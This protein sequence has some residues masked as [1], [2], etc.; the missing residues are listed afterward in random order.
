MGTQSGYSP[1][2]A[3][4][5]GDALRVELD[6][7][8]P[9]FADPEYRA[10]RDEIAAISAGYRPGSAIARVDY[11]ETEHDVWRIVSRELAP[12]HRRYG[13]RAFVEAAETLSL[14]VDHVPQLDEVTRRLE[15]ITGFTYRP[16]AGLAPLREFY[17]AFG[18]RRFFSTQYLR[19][20]SVPLYTPE[21]DI[22]HEVI[23]HA[24]QLADPSFASI[25]EEVGSAVARTE[26]ID[27]LAF[28]SK[29]FWFTLE[30]G[31]GF[32]GEE[33]KAYGAGILSSFGE[34]DVFQAAEIRPLDFAEM[35]S[36]EY[37]I[38]HYQPVLYAAASFEELVGELTTFYATYD[39]EAY[40]RLLSKGAAVG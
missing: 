19:H 21:P 7:G 27:A 11:S 40:E 14:P 16:V 34:L 20:H 26:S 8:H 28:M 32:E 38:T 5:E 24:N 6:R 31:V 36:T 4:G 37:D 33:P 35:G 9:G 15:P 2:V 22:I 12:K 13:C 17:G 25:C 23:G 10:R 39:D 3:S 30:F 29:V 18:E 1:V